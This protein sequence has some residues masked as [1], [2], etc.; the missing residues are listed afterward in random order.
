MAYFNLAQ[1]L[2]GFADVDRRL[3]E[4][5]RRRWALIAPRGGEVVV[6]R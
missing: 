2:G 6:S 3:T 4:H 5:N 1:K